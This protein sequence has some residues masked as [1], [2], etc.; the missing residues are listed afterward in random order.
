MSRLIS[1]ETNYGHRILVADIKHGAIEN[2][3]KMAEACDKID[4]IYLFG[5]SLENRCTEESDIDLAIVSSVT[6]SRLF[7]L[8]SYDTFVCGLYKYDKEQEY[9]ILQFNS[10]DKILNSAE[11]VCSDIAE[12]GKLI[13]IRKEL[14]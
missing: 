4:Y 3:I 5:S 11:F 13:Y 10:V 8:K 14:Q 2:I 12:K 7:R 9:D 1:V 6:R